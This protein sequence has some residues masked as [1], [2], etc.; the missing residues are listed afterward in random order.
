[1]GISDKNLHQ[2]F[3]PFFTTKD[4]GSGTGLGLATSLKI[5]RSWGGDIQVETKVGVG[6]K[7]TISLNT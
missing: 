1:M 2:L 6:T 4:I 3:K 5:V 7:F